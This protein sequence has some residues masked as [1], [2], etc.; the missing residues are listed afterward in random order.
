MATGKILNSPAILTRIVSVTLPANNDHVSV[1][2]PAVSGYTFLCWLGVSS[3][4][5]VKLGYLDGMLGATQGLWV[6]SSRSEATRFD[7]YA[8]YR[9]GL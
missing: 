4:G 7:A 1:T 9:K 5:S 6:E 8:L 2:A 3:Q